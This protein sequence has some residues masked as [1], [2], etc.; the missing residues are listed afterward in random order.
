MSIDIRL[1][2]ITATDEAGQLS[3]MRSYLYQFAE[4]LKWALNTLENNQNSD[5]VVL[6]DAVGNV[7]NIRLS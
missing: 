7:V 5:A 1:P 6:K 4:Q 3:Q 2:N